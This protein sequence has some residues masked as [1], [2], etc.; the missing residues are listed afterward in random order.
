MKKQIHWLLPL[1]LMFGL[2]ACTPKDDPIEPS[3]P[4]APTGLKLA[5]RT[6]TSL[7]FSWESV[8]GVTEYAWQLDQGGKTVQNGKA[9]TRNVTI[10][11]LAEGTAYRF[12]VQSVSGVATSSMSWIDAS[13]EGS[14][15]PP[16][17]SGSIEYAEFKIPA[18]EE[19]GKARAFP[20]AEGGGMYTAG[21][22]G[23]KVYHVT[24]LNDSGEGSLRY[25]IKSYKENGKAVR[26]L[27]IV[28]DVSGIIALNSPLKIEKD[29]SKDLD[30]GHLTIAG[31]TAPGAGI[32]LKNYTLNIQADDV[33][34]RFL[35]FRLGD[36]GPNAGDSED[37]IWGRYLSNV[38]IDHCSMSWSIDECAS[39]YAN[40]FMTLQWCILTE[41][42]NDSAHSKGAHGYGGIWGGK[43]ASFH[44]NMLANHH[45]RNP[46]IDHPEIYPKKNGVFDWSKRGNVD[47]RNL[48]I[49]NW[50]DNS[51]YGG[52]G[53]HYNLVNCYYKPGP[54]SHDRYYFVDAYSVYSSSKTDYGY[55]G[56]YMSGNIHT[57][58]DDIS[59]NNLV[60]GIY[61]HE[62]SS[63]D[64]PT[65]YSFPTAAYPI[66]GPDG[67]PVY[68]STHGTEA[69]VNA[70]L[71]WA[72][73]RL[74]RD[75][76]DERAVSGFRSNTGK[77]INTP[78]DVGGWPAYKQEKGGGF[79][80]W[81][82]DPN[83]YTLDPQKRYTNL[84]MYLHYLVKDIVE[85]GNK[86]ATYGQL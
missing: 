52:E 57:Q 78:S 11:E 49:Y 41:S 70:V 45:S 32:C 21:G 55:P 69:G 34:I 8:N 40:E 6:S 65:D 51:T 64:I 76:V 42:M 72:G 3:A 18:A 43:D 37:C 53:G 31:Q 12:G 38:I 59:A 30:E 50:G 10:R 86:G 5:S 29:E 17:P 14:T 25:G 71:D 77:I 63:F 26:P 61:F 39:F 73:D 2:A 24:N 75:S 85:G 68:T 56:L 36:E 27:T 19:D 16:Q 44:H 48:V 84:E 4:S 74:H 13:T 46:R 58:H 47:L 81:M 67:K 80:D 20:G 66:S 22:R 62:K 83:A 79:P 82:G 9:T 35:H 28:F 54:D 33:I 7:T 23:G 15:T 1:A 60:H